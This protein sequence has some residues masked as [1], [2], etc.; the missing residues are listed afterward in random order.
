LTGAQHERPMRRV[1]RRSSL[2]QSAGDGF[3]DLSLS[4]RAACLR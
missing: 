2:L 4:M 1:E 3:R